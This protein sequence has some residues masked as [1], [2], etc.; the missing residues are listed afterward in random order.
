MLTCKACNHPLTQIQV[1]SYWAWQCLVFACKQQKW[2]TGG[3]PAAT[4]A[5][6]TRR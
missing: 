2:P 5:E 6:Q 3:K 1:G 4:K